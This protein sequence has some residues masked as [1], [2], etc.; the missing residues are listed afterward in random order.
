MGQMGHSEAHSA[1][2]Q[3][4]WKLRRIRC[5]WHSPMQ[6]TDR[7]SLPPP[8]DRRATATFTL[9]ISGG[10]WQGI[11]APADIAQR[12]EFVRMIGYKG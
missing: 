12:R 1:K 11:K 10:S 4:G 7:R 9:V 2:A 6:R 5:D 3:S 8:P